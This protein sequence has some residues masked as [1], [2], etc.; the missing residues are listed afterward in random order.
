VAAIEALFS[1]FPGRSSRGFLG[2]SAVYL[3]TTDKGRRILFDT[4][5]YNERAT[6]IAA[7]EQRGL[8]PDDIDVLVLSHLHFDH[9]ANWD[10]FTRANIF[11][12]QIEMEYAC[13]PQADHAELR[14]HARAL[15]EERNVRL[16]G[17]D[18]ELESGVELLHVP[19]HTPGSMAVKIG[20]SVLCGDALKNRWD[21]QGAVAQPVWDAQQFRSSVEKLA[22]FAKKLC[23]GHDVP[24]QLQATGWLPE[25]KPS[26]RVMF[27][28]GIE[29]E[30]VIEP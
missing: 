19:G 9:A 8:S 3:I 24:L 20:G 5:G 23:P 11:V 29:Q 18:C 21:L 13:S 27:G 17:A 30:L 28:N 7:L 16:I 4:A 22:G 1:G 10:L 25:G 26:V 15:R 12:H 6:L 2:W 14:Y